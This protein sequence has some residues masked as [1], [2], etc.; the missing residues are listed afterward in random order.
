MVENTTGE[1]GGVHDSG[2]LQD[3]LE[4]VSG[5]NRI[6]ESKLD[7][8]HKA[9][10]KIGLAFVGKWRKSEDV[11]FLVDQALVGL[12]GEGGSCAYDS[13]SP[14][15]VANTQPVKSGLGRTEV[16]SGLSGIPL[17]GTMKR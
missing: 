1:D 2:S 11:G 3:S 12:F 15:V 16:P 14:G 8:L 7:A 10:H 17:S 5:R 4:L 9:L 13:L 6:L